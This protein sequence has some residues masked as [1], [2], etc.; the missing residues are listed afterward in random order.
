MM[1]AVGYLET[2]KLSLAYDQIHQS[3]E[4]NEK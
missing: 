4:E 1:N 2:A 3:K